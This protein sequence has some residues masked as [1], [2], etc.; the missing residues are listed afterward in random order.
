MFRVMWAGRGFGMILH[1][2]NRQCAMA[3]AFD[4]IVVEVNVGDFNFI[5]QRLSLH[6]KAMIMRSN[7]HVTVARIPDRLIAA[8]MTEHQFES[9]P[10]ES[11]AQ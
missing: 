2:N 8:T 10:T 11:S 1:G 7:L 9:L 5:W 6:G 4:A 3:H